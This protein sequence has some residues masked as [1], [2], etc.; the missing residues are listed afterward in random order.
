MNQWLIYSIVKSWDLV[1]K[2]LGNRLKEKL[3]NAA[4]KLL[5][6]FLF[7][8]VKEPNALHESL[9]FMKETN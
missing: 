8:K 7:V 9:P 3:R 6:D 1:W 5:I 4:L 2:A